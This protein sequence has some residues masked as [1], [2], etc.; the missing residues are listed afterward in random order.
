MSRKI[1]RNFRFIFLL[2]FITLIYLILD[3]QKVLAL[4]IVEVNHS[5]SNNNDR[6]IK[7][8]NDG[9]NI[10]DFTI[11]DFKT[12]DHKATTTK[13]GISVLLGAKD[14]PNNSYVYIS[15]SNNLPAGANKVFK[16]NFDLDKNNGYI[17]L[18]NSDNSGIYACFQYGNGLC[19][20]NSNFIS[21]NS[22]TSLIL[23]LNS[24][25]VSSLTSANS[26]LSATTSTT[27]S[28]LFSTTTSATSS[29]L[30]SNTNVVYVYVNNTNQNNLQ[31][32]YGDILVLL[33]ETR[34]V[35][36]MAEVDYTV[37]VTDSQKKVLS[38]LDFIWS[39]GDG[40][41][42]F[43]QNV[44]YYY[45]YPGEYTLIAQADGYLG[46]GEAKM[47]VKVYQPEI[48]ILKVGTSI[49]EN[50][51]ELK[52]HTNYDVYLSN[53]YL[54]IDE[55]D[56]KLP[57]NFAIAKNQSV[58]V[59]G[60]ALGFKMPALKFS[61]LY[62]NKNILYEYKY[63]Y[64]YLLATTTPTSVSAIISTTSL[65]N[66]VPII[67]AI[68]TSTI[69]KIINEHDNENAKVTVI[70]NSENNLDLSSAGGGPA[71]GGR[72]SSTIFSN[73]L[74]EKSELALLEKK[75]ISENFSADISD[76]QKLKSSVDLNIIKWLKSLLY[77]I[78]GI[79]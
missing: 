64:K 55:Q 15:P 17:Q 59:A 48:S 24:L 77:Y 63:E 50:Y 9:N 56:F 57:K 1:S 45:N 12:L 14:F 29:N 53:F 76:S 23:D 43:G 69:S 11:S 72:N 39:F 40:G 34:E 27:S 41:E 10:S 18:I 2:N 31:N 30:N 52:N 16:S 13:H 35:P 22:T 8:L 74:A 47:K 60:Q 61:L 3:F 73:N 28:N 20:N 38:G 68:S 6:W 42:K 25:T 71:S 58:K 46:R 19:P 78:N 67:S 44:N 54:R 5:A 33:P 26:N 65:I 37:K 21:Y 32:K 66:S 79:W 36:A 62:P 51:I 70:N 7:I 4:Q 75:D 49:L